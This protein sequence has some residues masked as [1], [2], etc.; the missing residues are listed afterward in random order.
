LELASLFDERFVKR[1]EPLGFGAHYKMKGIREIH[2]LRCPAQRLKNQIGILR[3]HVSQRQQLSE[4]LDHEAPR[5][6][7]LAQHPGKLEYDGNGDPVFRARV[8]EQTAGRT[9]L[10]WL[11]PEQVAR[12]DMRIE[13][14][15][16]RP[17]RLLRA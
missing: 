9:R 2:T 13:R 7:G 14:N 4:F 3:A 6:F 15:Q 5:R 8:L 11:V 16:R 17:R 1:R 12:K 10:G